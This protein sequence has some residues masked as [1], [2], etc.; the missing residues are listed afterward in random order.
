MAVITHLL[1]GLNFCYQT[2]ISAWFIPNR[3]FHYDISSN[4]T[5]EKISK[6]DTCIES[7]EMKISL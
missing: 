6:R 7:H 1:L 4:I 3:H 5:G 2:T